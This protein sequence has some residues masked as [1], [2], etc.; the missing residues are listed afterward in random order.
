[1]RVSILHTLYIH[2][3]LDSCILLHWLRCRRTFHISH[4]VVFNV[5][6][7]FE[8]ITF[9]CAFLYISLNH[10]PAL[11]CLYRSCRA[12]M[13]AFH[14]S[15]EMGINVCLSASPVVS[16]LLLPLALLPISICGPP[17]RFIISGGG[18]WVRGGSK[19]GSERGKGGRRKSGEGCAW[20]SRS[21]P[22]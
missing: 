22:R 11:P 9:F 1:M 4:L 13:S 17:R 8:I 14:E 10:F 15:A 2:V 21:G 5:S 12:S 20:Q 6:C 19:R 16:S 18:M 7:V 3:C